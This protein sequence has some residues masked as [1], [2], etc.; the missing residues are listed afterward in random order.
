MSGIA[1]IL[2]RDGRD[3]PKNWV[4]YLEQSLMLDG[5][6][7]HRF[8]DSIPVQSG[9]LHIHLLGPGPVPGPVPGP[10][11]VDGEFEGEC[12][13]AIW[14]PETLELELGRRGTG[15]KPLY[16]LD[17]ADAGDG[18]VFCSNPLPL[19]RIAK[20]LEL[21][22]EYLAKGVQE[23]LQLGFTPE[24]GDLLMPVCSLPT[25]FID[26]DVSQ[27]VSDL[28]CPISTTVAEDV[29]TLVTIFGL[30]FADSS[31]LSTLWQYREA[32]C[33]ARRIIDGVGESTQNAHTTDRGLSRRIA[34][35]AIANHVGVDVRMTKEH[36]HI[37][38]IPIPLETWFRS[39]QSQLGQLLDKTIR[40]D[41][42]FSGLPVKQQDV[43]AMHVAHMHGENHTEQL[44]ALL[45][46][47]LWYQQVL[48]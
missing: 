42:A 27:A 47:S 41:E 7:P 16:W 12:A 39:P 10:I 9:N 6:I 36:S 28:S 3:V 30:P 44:F 40:A 46:L 11:L 19:H 21:T 32:K 26:S 25:E 5:E 23:Y 45:T 37:E 17:L 15:Q 18:F 43:I 8:E 2:R 14:K 35:N 31:Y 33:H 22:N 34:L 1:G 4:D 20:E 29:L 13:F 24:G 48:A 38:A